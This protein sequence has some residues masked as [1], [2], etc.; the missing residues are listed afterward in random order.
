MYMTRSHKVL[1]FI[2]P[3]LI[4]FTILMT[5]FVVRHNQNL[6][7]LH[8]TPVILQS[9]T[10]T[11][12]YEVTKELPP[13]EVALPPIQTE[14]PRRP[15]TDDAIA[16]TM[17]VK[18]CSDGSFVGRTAPDCAF[19]ACPTEAKDRTVLECS[20]ESRLAEMCAEIYAP[21]C[22][23]YQVQ[24]VTTPCPPMP[25]TYENDCKACMDNNVLSYTEGA[26]FGLE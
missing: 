23:S 15:V 18:M 2:P 21:V 10:T 6:Q 22:T 20:P 25:K 19:A 7:G 3:L 14:T 16:C 9:S 5:F 17:E 1:V 24:C 4:G 11:D 26:C 8:D 13:S 12:G